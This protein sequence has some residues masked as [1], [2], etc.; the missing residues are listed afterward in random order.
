MNAT[1]IAL[2]V[3]KLHFV[4]TADS[5]EACP[6]LADLFNAFSTCLRSVSLLPWDTFQRLLRPELLHLLVDVIRT[7]PH[8]PLLIPFDLI[9][10]LCRC[11]GHSPEESERVRGLLDKS[12]LAR[13][14]HAAISRAYDPVT[15]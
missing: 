2:H 7:A 6:W 11:L 10:L 14:L 1:I 4:V 8:D 3:A 5:A 15:T 13:V 9:G 12:Q